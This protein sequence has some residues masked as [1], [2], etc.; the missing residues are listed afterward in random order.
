[1]FLASFF[2]ASSVDKLTST[3]GSLRSKSGCRAIGLGSIGNWSSRWQVSSFFP[4]YLRRLLA[5][6]RGEGHA[7]RPVEKRDSLVEH[8]PHTFI[9]P[10]SRCSARM[11]WPI[12]LVVLGL[13]ERFYTLEFPSMSQHSCHDRGQL[14]CRYPCQLLESGQLWPMCTLKRDTKGPTLSNQPQRMT[15]RGV[16]MQV[17][18]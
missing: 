5:L 1:M 13:T 3:C 12:A 14:D 7:Y 4:G 18:L 2:H 11:E 10:S 17:P 8:G 9:L 6:V 15:H 16:T